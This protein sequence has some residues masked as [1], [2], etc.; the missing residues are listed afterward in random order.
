MELVSNTLHQTQFGRNSLSSKV[1]QSKIYV[2]CADILR[3]IVALMRNKS[4]QASF[5]S[6]HT[7]INMLIKILTYREDMIQIESIRLLH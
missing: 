1:N 4:H 2:L 5:C 7:N 6:V 3:F